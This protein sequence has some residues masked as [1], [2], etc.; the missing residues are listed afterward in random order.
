MDNS[1]IK[2]YFDGFKGELDGLKDGFADLKKGFGEIKNDFADLRNEFGEIKN[3]FGDLKRD[4]GALKSDVGDLKR[5]VGDLKIDVGA[6]KRDVGDLKIDVGDLKRDVDDLKSDVGDLKIDVGDLK[7]DVGDLR[8][9]MRDNYDRLSLDIRTVAGFKTENYI[10]IESNSPLVLSEIGKK[11]VEKSELSSVVD[12]HYPYIK[13]VLHK[14]DIKTKLRLQTEINRLM[15]CYRDFIN[16]SDQIRIENEAYKMGFNE[17]EITHSLTILF[18]D[19][20]L[21]EDPHLSNVI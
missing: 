1:E 5:D 7:I 10:S 14:K 3:E 12:K 17:S 2:Q 15:V 11:F 13:G 6:L 19:K 16:E 4:V 9:E 18:R 21:Q 8:E 20:Y